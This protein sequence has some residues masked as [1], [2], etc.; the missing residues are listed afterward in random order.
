[1]Q[2]MVSLRE[3][4][5]DRDDLSKRAATISVKEWRQRSSLS[6]L[7]SRDV[8]CVNCKECVFGVGIT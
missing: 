2:G 3:K 4:S 5:A 8:A 1:M 7:F 6:P